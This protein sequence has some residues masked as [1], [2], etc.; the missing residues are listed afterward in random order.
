MFPSIFKYLR[1]TMHLFVFEAPLKWFYD[2]AEMIVKERK[3]A[4]DKV[5]HSITVAGIGLLV[6]YRGVRYN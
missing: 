2:T 5:Y 3:Q 4:K 6:E 1:K